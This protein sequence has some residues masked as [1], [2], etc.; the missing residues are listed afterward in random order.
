MSLAKK[1]PALPCL[2]PPPGLVAWWPGN[3]TPRDLINHNNGSLVGDISYATGMVGKA[4]NFMNGGL[5]IDMGVQI[6]AS[7][8][9]DVRTAITMEAWI[10]PDI[11][12][13]RG[14]ILEYVVDE[15]YGNYQG[16]HMWIHPSSST[17]Y[18]NF[19]DMAGNNHIIFVDGVVRLGQFQH[20]ATSYDKVTG[21]G[22]LYLDGALILEQYLGSFDLKTDCRF[23]IGMRET[24]VW[25]DQGSFNGLID[26]AGIF[27]RALEPAEV[28]AI[29]NAG[30]GGKCAP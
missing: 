20:V 16:P 9:L 7:S 25:G 14:P 1:P 28:L 6:P 22:R 17:L 30:A 13:V 27:N 2:P 11:D 18:A 23:N 4:F 5:G 21:L 24:P 12:M 10:W 29:F 26:E 3:G 19:M 15:Y 8:S